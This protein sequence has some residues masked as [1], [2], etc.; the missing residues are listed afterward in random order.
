MGSRAVVVLCRS[1]DVARARFGVTSGALGACF[2]RTGRRF[3]NDAALE[4]TFLER[5]RASA[6]AAGLWDTLGSDWVCLDAELMPW[7]LKASELVRDQYAAVGAAAGAALV[8]VQSVL[9]RASSRGLDV[10]TLA[11]KAQAQAE[12]VARYNAAWQ[13]YCWTVSSLD[14]VK[15]APF[16]VLASEGAV[17]VDKDHHWHLEM[18][19]GLARADGRLIVATTSRTVR[20]DD[21]TQVEAAIEWWESLTA[22]GGEGM[23]VKPL[24]FI[25]RGGRGLVQPALKCRGRD[26]LRII[27]GPDYAAPEHLERLRKRGL[28]AK[29]GLAL[30]EFSLGVEALERFVRKEPLRRVHEA[31][32]A[33]LALESEPVDPRL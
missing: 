13:R 10:S 29:R 2:T 4:D 25:A 27:Y 11:A 9:A 20:L 30:R 23:V 1:A 8:D 17:H 26:Y 31:V 33:V 21:A 22:S 15:L 18:L 24:T 19:A 3:F 14:D 5:L 6:E 7:S 16:H 28:S 12:A 32:F